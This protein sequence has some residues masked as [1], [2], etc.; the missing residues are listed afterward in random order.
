MEW[1][2]KDCKLCSLGLSLCL[3][4]LYLLERPSATRRVRLQMCAN[5]FGWAASGSNLSHLK[6]EH[7]VYSEME[8]I[9][10]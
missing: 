4:R 8:N 9:G 5:Y 7:Y 3:Q 6:E 10:T 1:D 2:N